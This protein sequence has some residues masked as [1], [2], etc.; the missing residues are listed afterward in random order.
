MHNYIE[1]T[2]DWH[3]VCCC[4]SID[5]RHEGS[6]SCTRLNGRLEFKFFPNLIDQIAFNRSD[7]VKSNVCSCR[8]QKF[9]E[10][11]GTNGGNWRSAGALI[12]SFLHCSTSRLSLPAHTVA[13]QLLVTS[14]SNVAA[15]AFMSPHTV[16]L[17][18]L[19]SCHLT[20]QRCSFY[21]ACM[22][23]AACVAASMMHACIETTGS[24][25]GESSL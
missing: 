8:R 10:R 2:K 11:R 9:M 14:H 22:L 17:Q 19:Y 16:A 7:S 15:S 23:S 20:Q 21:D 24:M 4:A 1:R 18:L 3:A 5:I 13:L 6:I 12:H 25:R